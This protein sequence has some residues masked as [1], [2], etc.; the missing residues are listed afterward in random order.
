MPRVEIAVTRAASSTPVS[1]SSVT[2]AG[3]PTLTLEMSDSLKATVIVI[4]PVST[5]STNPV[6]DDEDELLEPVELLEPPRLEPV[7]ALPVAEDP[8]LLDPVDEDPE[9]AELLPETVS[10]GEMASTEM[11]VPVA[12]A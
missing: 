5:I 3:C 8:V 4:D 9:L 1:A 7:L 6:L 11:T 2:V 12:G 10:P